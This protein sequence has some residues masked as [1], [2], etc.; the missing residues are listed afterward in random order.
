VPSIATNPATADLI[1]Y[2]NSTVTI[3]D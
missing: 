1:T 3:P 2:S